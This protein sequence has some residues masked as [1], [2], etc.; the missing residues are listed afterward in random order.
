MRTLMVIFLALCWR[1]AMSQQQVLPLDDYY[2]LVRHNH[3]LARQAQLLID[4]GSLEVSEARGAFDPVLVS[5]YQT[6]NFQGTDYF[7]I[8][9]SYVTLPTF[10]N[11][12]LKAG[13]E[14]S[15]GSFL[16]PE[17]NLPDDGLYYAGISVPLGQGL[18]HNPRNIALKKSKLQ[19]QDLQFEALQVRNN[20]LL[21]ATVSY[22]QWQEAF[23]KFRIIQ[24]NLDL[25][26]ERFQG[27]RQGVLNGE[28]AAI[29][30]VEAMIQWQQ[31]GNRLQKAQL[32]Y[33]NSLLLI[34]NFIWSDSLDISGAAPAREP[35]TLDT[36][37]RILMDFAAQ[38]HPQWRQLLL[39]N[40][41]L[42]LE[43]KLSAEQIKPIINV[44]Y[45]L[46][47]EDSNEQVNSG[48]L[49]NNYK[50]GVEF[51]FPLLVRKERAALK[52]KKL[53]LQENALKQQQ[54]LREMNNKIQ[55]YYNKMLTL[56]Q[57]IEQQRAVVENYER[58]LLG[59]RTKFANGESSIFLVNNRE[60]QKLQAE[61]KLVE[62][63]AE[64]G[65]TQGLVQWSSGMLGKIDSEELIIKN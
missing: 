16:N 59:E 62:M 21:D 15:S 50:G 45:N 36:N 13:Y 48:F 46:L 39:K 37:P 26:L 52:M 28:N 25:I 22:W 53:E 17:R 58:L 56:R 20:L 7:D 54:K 30:S 12:E 55:Q 9:D 4:K 29:D 42:E 1:P 38:N 31:W 3:P 6:K 2:Q 18:I 41:M 61:F 57:Q 19:Q 27:I 64:Y 51:K 47:L 65:I 5:N 32:D 43:R 14:R 35:G 60:N 44:N 24:F 40:G 34:Q 11:V 63:T 10:M 23:E 8:W 33:Q 49:S